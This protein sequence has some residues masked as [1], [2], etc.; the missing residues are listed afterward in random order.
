MDD[1]STLT[2]RIMR[3]P[4]GTLGYVPLWW[5]QQFDSQARKNHCDQS[6]S[7]LL[8]RG[9]LSAREALA[10]ATGK[11]WSAV[12][13]TTEAVAWESL[14]KLVEVASPGWKCGP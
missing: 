1:E 10:A 13:G 11:P 12:A 8:Q 14:K 4:S 6:I 5:M 3:E 2:F 7:R 9:G